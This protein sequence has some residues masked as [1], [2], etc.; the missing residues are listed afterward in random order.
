MRIVAHLVE[1][2]IILQLF[3]ALL[4]LYLVGVL[5]DFFVFW[6]QVVLQLPF[7]EEL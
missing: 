7:Y 5:R 6:H 3:D 2:L 1:E 4:K